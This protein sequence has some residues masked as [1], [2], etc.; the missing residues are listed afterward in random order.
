MDGR[1]IKEECVLLVI[2]K[3]GEG[4]GDILVYL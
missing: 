2:E 3:R 1:R 4:K